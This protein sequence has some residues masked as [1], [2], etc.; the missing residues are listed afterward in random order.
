MDQ[1]NS[2]RSIRILH[3]L[4]AMN[5]GGVEVWLMHLL[6]NIDREKFQMDFLVQSAGRYDSEITALGSR[7][8]RGAELRKPWVF[9][10]NMR[11]ALKDH[12]P[13]DVVHSH[14]HHYSGFVL[15][16]AKHAGV[17]V[18]IAHSHNDLYSDGSQLS[19]RRRA[20]LRIAKQLVRRAATHGL[21]CSQRAAA[22]L[23]DRGWK[24]DARWEVLPY[25]V[26]LRPFEN[27]PAAESLRT[28]LGIPQNALVLG[29]VGSFTQQKNHT[30]LIKVAQAVMEREPRAHL[31]LVGDG[32]LKSNIEHAAA[33]AG[34]AEQVSFAGLRDDVP[35]MMRDIMD[36]F[37]FPSKYEGLGLV[38]VEA[39]A[40]GLPC[41]FSDTVPSEAVVVPSL[42]RSVSL[43]ETAHSWANHVMATCSVVESNAEAALDAVR[44]SQYSMGR[45][46]EKIECMYCNACDG[47]VVVSNSGQRLL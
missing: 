19:V 15:T 34:I 12:G 9:V 36:V 14:V 13:Y 26:D 27:G 33:E 35:T 25:G 45:N 39:Q 5:P 2:N 43:N 40:A 44:N 3:V 30:F 7:V 22:S 18:R 4:G 1:N 23:F 37:L 10:R 41:V 20:Y 16:V 6:R 47:R 29:H 31:L 38:L 8:I 17:P 21:A 11:Q 24:R 32:P 46:V 42:M 28:D